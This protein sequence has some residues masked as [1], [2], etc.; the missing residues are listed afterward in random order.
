MEEIIFRGCI[1]GILKR[2]I[3]ITAALI[4]Q[5]L[6]FAIIH[7]NIVQSSYVFFLGLILGF[8]FIYTGSLLGNI[9]CHIIFNL[10][11]MMLLPLLASIYYSPIIYIIIGV[12]LIIFSLY[13]Y[14]KEQKNIIKIL[15]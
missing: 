10:L 3:N 11:G 5:A 12:M 1:F 13:L 6:V 7:E 8:T 2:N 15:V 14:K 4:I 9:I